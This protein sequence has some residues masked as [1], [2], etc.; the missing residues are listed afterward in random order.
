MGF[1][2]DAAGALKA[3]SG[4]CVPARNKSY[5]AFGFGLR[6]VSRGLMTYLALGV[7]APIAVLVAN[8]IWNFGGVVVIVGCFV[9]IGFAIVLVQPSED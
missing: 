1:A 8:V 4:A 3:H 7:V 2:N 9:W 5:S 6:M